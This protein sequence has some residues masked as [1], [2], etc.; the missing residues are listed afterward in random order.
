VHGVAVSQAAAGPDERGF[1]ALRVL[2]WCGESG[3]LAGRIL[4]GLGADVI[5]IEPPGGDLEARRPP[6]R[7]DIA[8]PE[9]SLPWQA[10]EAGKRGIVLDLES[11]S[12]REDY[13]RLARAA[14]VVIETFAPGTLAAHGLGFED[15]KSSNPGLVH[16]AITPFGQTGP[17]ASYRA[18]DLVCVAMGGNLAVTGEPTR[19]PLR[20]SQPTAYYH[21]GPEAVL[22]IFLALR[23]RERSGRGQ[24]VDVSLQETQLQTL[25]GGPGQPGRSE[26]RRAGERIGR[27]RE[28]WGARDG[29]LSYGLRGGR[30]RIP[31]LNATVA[32]MAESGMASDW[33]QAFS[34]SGYSHLEVSDEDLGRIEAEFGA[35]FASKTLAELYAGALERRILLAPCNDARGIAGHAQLRSRDLF[36]EVGDPSGGGHTLQPDFFAK[37]RNARAAIRRPAPRIGEHQAAVLN[38]SRSVPAAPPTSEAVSA[39]GIC[40]GLR[41]LELGSGAAGPVATRYFAEH[42]AHVIRIES[43]ERPDFLRVLFITADSRFGV[44]GSPMFVLLNPNKDSVTLNL[45]HPE[46]RALAQ[47]LVAWADVLCENYA[48]GVMEKFGLDYESLRGVN[49]G[50]VMVSGCLFGQTGP[51]RGYPGFGAQGSAISGFN[52][53]TGW[54]DGP[55]LGPYG[56]I[57]DSLSPRFVALSLAAALWRRERS[58]EGEC[59]DVSQIETAVYCLAEVVARFSASGEIVTRRGNRSETCA[60]V[61]VYPCPGEDR[62][63][64]IEVR[65]DDEWRALVGVMGRPEW[66]RDASLADTAGRLAAASK[67][68]EGLAAWTRGMDAFELMQALQQAGVPAGVVQT[69]ADLRA[70]PQ[71]AHRGHWVRLEHSNL[72]ELVFERSGFRFSG[73]SGGFERPGPN[74]GEHNRSVFEQILGLEH[75]EIDRLVEAGAIA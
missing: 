36:V 25:L 67:L 53:L 48:P 46:A 49:P 5:R 73:G 40:A 8:D 42:G 59:I 14:D 2:D 6:Y 44:D 28:I 15:L 71:L 3:A 11:A 31:N 62:W 63:I 60:P 52:H 41:V 33:L 61:G 64:A 12:D 56:T 54:P 58:G 35:F 1:A 66:A 23:G 50:L 38:E 47:R 75:G 57:T 22:A 19:P 7:G 34:W 17:Y 45:K 10:N 51:Q 69:F 30:A 21:A 4:A 18:G 55:A 37:F 26:P 24:F 74:L 20:C 27:T 65:D 43:G 39:D 9:Q 29:M 16:C 68:D 32:W 72:G 70:D 13:R